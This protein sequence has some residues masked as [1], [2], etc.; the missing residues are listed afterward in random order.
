MAIRMQQYIQMAIIT[1][2]NA[3]NFNHAYILFLISSYFF[4]IHKVVKFGECNKIKF[5]R[6]YKKLYDV[7]AINLHE[8][9]RFICCRLMNVMIL[10][11]CFP[12]PFVSLSCFSI[13]T[14]LLIA[15][16]Y[17]RFFSFFYIYTPNTH[18]A[19]LLE[20]FCLKKTQVEEKKNK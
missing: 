6:C 9:W 14:N 13:W 12:S 7:S 2:L 15:I 11:I 10:F 19:L 5:L 18:R 3:F 16:N 17:Y 4:V 8:K 1:N 20:G